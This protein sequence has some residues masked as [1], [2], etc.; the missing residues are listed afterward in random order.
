MQ[1]IL[2]YY[3]KPR[4]IF[5]AT[6]YSIFLAF[7]VFILTVDAPNTPRVLV[8]LLYVLLLTMLAPAALTAAKTLYGVP[9]YT[10]NEMGITYF[11]SPGLVPWQTIDRLEAYSPEQTNDKTWKL[12]IKLKKDCDYQ[13]NWWVRFIINS[14]RRISHDRADFIIIASY[15]TAPAQPTIESILSIYRQYCEQFPQK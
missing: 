8:V 4:A 5:I 11:K 13:Y 9:M 12:F 2:L 1:P 15:L 6:I 14:N 10:I 3:R 7:F